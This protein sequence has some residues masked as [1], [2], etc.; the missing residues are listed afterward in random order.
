M[1]GDHDETLG[2]VALDSAIGCLGD[3]IPNAAVT[4]DADYGGTPPLGY[5]RYEDAKVFFCS[6]HVPVVSRP[7]YEI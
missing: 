4:G 6:R 3:L 2:K 1:V 7:V 5:R